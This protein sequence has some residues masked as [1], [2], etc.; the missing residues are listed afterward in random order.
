M[1]FQLPNI[2]LQGLA[3][4][5]VN[6]EIDLR[7]GQTNF[8]IIG[9]TD[10]A[11][12]EARSRIAAAIKNSGFKF[13]VNHRLTINLAPAHLHKE[14]TAFDLAMAIGIIMASQKGNRAP[15]IKNTLILGELALNGDLRYT[16]GILPIVA[17]ARKHGFK[18]II[19]PK[20]T[21]ANLNS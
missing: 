20:K 8:L 16:K 15:N 21:R 2:A 14:G 12:Q 1:F 6:I 5:P 7:I 18:E 10:A 4:V 19:L 11:I 17:Q 3:T 9:L 13:P